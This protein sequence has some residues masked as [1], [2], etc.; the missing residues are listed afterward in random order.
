MKITHTKG[1]WTYRQKRGNNAYE[2][3]VEV[4]GGKRI[5]EMEANSLDDVTEIKANCKLIAAAPEMLEA[6]NYVIKWHRE[7][8]SGAG[9]LFG[10]DFVTTCI[11][12]KRKAIE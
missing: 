8:D 1:E 4:P 11:A 7:H 6:L 12:A 3:V 10:L 2:Y 9:E 5:A